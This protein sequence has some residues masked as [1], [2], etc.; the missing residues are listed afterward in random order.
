MRFN[1]FRKS[2]PAH[3]NKEMTD[4]QLDEVYQSMDDLLWKCHHN[5]E[6]FSPI[7]ARLRA[8]NVAEEGVDM[9][10]AMLIL[11]RPVKHKVEYR[12]DFY[13]QSKKRLKELDRDW[14]KLIGG[15]E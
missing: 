1:F 2:V 13:K 4:S 10:L 3:P 15:L 12:K 14:K 5:H 7:E 6:D 11:S 9:I 8:V